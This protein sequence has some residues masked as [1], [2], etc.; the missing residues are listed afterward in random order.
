M[1]QIVTVADPYAPVTRPFSHNCGWSRAFFLDASDETGK[2][3]V[4]RVIQSILKLRAQKVIAVATSAVAASFLD[5][6]RT[7]VSVSKI[8]IPCFSY[9]AC[10]MSMDSNLASKIRQ[11]NLIIWNVIVMCVRC[12]VE[13]VDRTL[14]AIIKSQN[15][16]FGG[17]CILFSVDFRQIPPVVPRE[18]KAAIIFMTLKSSPLF[19]HLHLLKLT[20]SVRL[21]LLKTDAFAS[22]LV[23]QY[24]KHLLELGEGR[25][26]QNQQSEIEF[27]SSVKFVPASTDLVGYVFP[28][29]NK[30]YM[31]S[32]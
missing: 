3:F 1:N 18:S 4:I 9:S 20:K 10:S 25:I 27:P 12:C 26:L 29:L 19:R 15:V 32:D 11:A 6:G 8:P 5:R 7:A 24:P 13:A 31:D 14:R 22:E 16:P 17:N 2:T 23:L 28:S 30:N 21:K